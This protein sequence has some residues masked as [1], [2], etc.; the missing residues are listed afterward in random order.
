MPYLAG[1]VAKLNSEGGETEFLSWWD[2][3]KHH[4]GGEEFNSIFT[5]YRILGCSED[6]RLG[7]EEERDVERGKG[8]Q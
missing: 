3:L 1:H 2:N 7:R 4:K 8:R 6:R 5:I